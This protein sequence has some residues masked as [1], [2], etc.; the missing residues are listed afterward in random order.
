MKRVVLDAS[1]LIKLFFDEQHSQEAARIVKN[2]DELLAPDL[3]WAEIANIIWKRL[4]RGAID[5]GEAKIVTQAILQVP[6]KAF[7]SE[8]L[9]SDAIELAS[10]TRCTAYDCLYLVAA[11][12]ADCPL[13]TADEKFA[14]MV[15]ATRDGLTGHIRVLGCK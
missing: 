7:P 8:E 12:R 3:I 4:S 2:A 6:I 5:R 9:I 1:V 10:I 13:I 14:N 11:I 15:K